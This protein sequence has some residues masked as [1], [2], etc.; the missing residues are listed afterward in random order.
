[1]PHKEISWMNPLHK[2]LKLADPLA[3]HIHI[4][5]SSPLV[6]SS[7]TAGSV[8]C[9]T[10]VNSDKCLGLDGTCQMGLQRNITVH[11]K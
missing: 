7:V 9:V 1:M 5:H 10:I 3:A 2:S 6:I 8:N 11:E 4:M